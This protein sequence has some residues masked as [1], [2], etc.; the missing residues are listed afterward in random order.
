MKSSPAPGCYPHAA[1][2]PP[3]S[4]LAVRAAHFGFLRQTAGHVLGRQDQQRPAV[5]RFLQSRIACRWREFPPAP[6]A[7]CSAARCSAL[8][9][10][11]ALW[12]PESLRR[13]SFPEIILTP[14]F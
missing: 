14:D 3:R 12:L 9:V 4:P 5:S 10:R 2:T 13:P 7:A 6:S 11:S 8:L 1:S